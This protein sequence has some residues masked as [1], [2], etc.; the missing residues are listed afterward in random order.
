[1]IAGRLLRT[2]ARRWS[3][4]A[5]AALLAGGVAAA[6]WPASAPPRVEPIIERISLPAGPGLPGDVVLDAA[7]YLPAVTPAPAV[8]VAHGFGGSRLSVDS[9]AQRLA[10]AGFAVLAYS[11]RGFGASTGMIGLDSLDYEVAD[12]RGLVDWL[13]HRPEIIQDAPGD[14]RVGVTGGSY[15]GALSLML[16]GTDP[17][18]D[19]VAAIATWN[20]LQ[21][22]LFP[23]SLAPVH[24]GGTP[25]AI[26]SGDDGVFKSAWTAAL[27]SSVLTNSRGGADRPSGAGSGTEPAGDPAAGSPTTGS[28]ASPPTCGRLMPALCAAYTE[29]AET[30]RLTPA[31]AKL[32]ARSSPAAVAGRITAPTLLV[33][34][35]ADTLFG[36]DQADANARAITGAPVAVSW[37]AGGHSG[38]A[39]DGG[40]EQRITDWFRHYLSGQGAAPSLAFRYPVAGPVSERGTPR[41]RTLQLPAYPGLDGTATPTRTVTL[42]GPRQQI[43]NPPGGQP[44]AITSLPGLSGGLSSLAALGTLPGQTA[45]FSS[46]P[47]TEPLVVTGSIPVTFEIA[48]LP[49]HSND[50]PRGAGSPNGAQPISPEAGA[51]LFFSLAASNGD[52]GAAATGQAA[53]P[54]APTGIA[55]A[56]GS[57]PAGGAVAAVR[58]KDLPADGSPARVTVQLPAVAFQVAVGKRLTVRVATTDQGYAG[59][60]L[61]ALYTI[62][63]ADQAVAVPAAGGVRAGGGDDAEPVGLA[64]GLAALVLLA[65]AGLIV[66]GRAAAPGSGAQ[67]PAPDEAAPDPLI[68]SGLAKEYP[69]GITAVADASFRLRRG[70]VL[71]LLGP[72]GAGK[73]TT[74]RMVMGLIAPTAGSIA[75]FGE[76]A[77]PGAPVL[78]RIGSFVEGSGFLPHLSGSANLDLYWRATGRPGDEAHI[79]E[80][81]AIAGLGGAVRRKVKTYSQG[82]R[83]RLAIAQAMLGLPDLLILDE[84][85]NGLDPP[86]IHAMREVLRRYAATGRT[87]LVSSHLLA[88]VEQT[89]SHVV[90]MSRGRTIAAGTVAEMVAASGE[91]TIGCDDPERAAGYLRG[92]GS[93]GEVQVTASGVTVDLGALGLSA[94][95]TGLLAEGCAISSAAPRNRLEDVF[96][97]LVGSG[98]NTVGGR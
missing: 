50:E 76:P 84:P 41:M 91:Y 58:L 38:G 83:Q 53:A 39:P 67:R 19:A 5:I 98:E 28:V 18:V 8:I 31:M 78:S 57:G 33:Q 89:C 88:E 51:V 94:V 92:L 79:S 54:G 16:A 59:A 63:L 87:V 45:Q 44:A 2:R 4:L 77:G 23:D 27:M 12:A 69:G 85:T 37:Y 43:F 68:I 26:G 21:Q 70:E 64:I 14:P 7:L 40:T 6:V 30:G 81:L 48:R 60:R 86:Q 82:M 29:V 42:S 96:L 35:E 93:V 90:V 3:A 47:L 10:A 36:L 9:D 52:S 17:R 75:I 74:L 1:M 66:A 65:A 15:G 62:S 13:A 56:L 24:G 72:N 71:G 34:G 20:D 46:E 73:T 11:A 97:E 80:A 22:A 49:N 32:L 61:P 95:L 55:A 25:A